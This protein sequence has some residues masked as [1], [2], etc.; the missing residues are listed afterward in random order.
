MSFLKPEYSN[1]LFYAITNTDGEI[2]Y[3]HKD[4]FDFD[5]DTLENHRDTIESIVEIRDKW[6]HRLSASG[7]LDC[8]DWAGPFDTLQ[9]VRDY[10]IEFWEMDPDTGESL[11]PEDEEE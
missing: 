9:E 1:E 7:Y 8:T 6:W 4:A 2:D 11:N 5:F 10:V 3:F